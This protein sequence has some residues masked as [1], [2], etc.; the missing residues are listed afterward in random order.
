M[1]VKTLIIGNGDYESKEVKRLFDDMGNEATLAASGRQGMKLAS[2]QHPDLII[3]DLA[4]HDISAI[5]VCRW[6]KLNMLTKKVPIIMLGGRKEI[7]E[8]IVCLKEGAVD[9][10]SKPVDQLELKVRFDSFVRERLLSD[11]LKMKEMEYNDLLTNVDSLAIFDPVTGLVSKERFQAIV[12]KELKRTS[13]Y[14]SPFSCLI[15][16]VDQEEEIIDS[17]G[18]E[19]RDK[20]LKSISEE[21]KE[22]VRAVDT[23]ARNGEKGF[24]LLLTEQD[25]GKAVLIATTI[26]ERIGRI[27]LE[28]FSDKEKKMSVSIGISSIPDP[29]IKRVQEVLVCAEY[30]L[31]KAKKVGR[32]RVQAIRMMEVE[33]GKNS[34]SMECLGGL[35]NSGIPSRQDKTFC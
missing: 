17:C 30:A 1:K 11:A 35:P 20:A 4:L 7:K 13:R 6:S 33:A 8:R 25:Q 26:S 15:I 29:G 19:V 21:I 10:I 34:R 12:A 5:E 23:L 31:D 28:E 32:G 18:Q 9:Y 16:E 3:L 27:S 2:A 24:M 14:K 22:Q